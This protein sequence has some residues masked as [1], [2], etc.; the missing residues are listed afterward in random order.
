MKT[1]T[2]TD[3]EYDVLCDVVGYQLDEYCDTAIEDIITNFVVWEDL[4]QHFTY[5]EPI[6]TPE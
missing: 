4:R 1:M 5:S 3:K 2:F 6:H